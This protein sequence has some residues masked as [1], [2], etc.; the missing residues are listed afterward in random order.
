MNGK[1]DVWAFV[2]EFRNQYPDMLEQLPVDVLSVIELELR[3][4]VIPFP[5]LFRKYSVDAAIVPDFSGIYVDA[6]SYA[7]LE[8]KPIRQFNRLRFS[9]AHELGHIVMH[10]DLAPKQGFKSLEDFRA[11]TQTYNAQRFTLEQ[12]ANEFGGRLVVPVDRLNADF[13]L[14]SSR[15]KGA[16]PDFWVDRAM[17]EGFCERAGESYGVSREVISVRLDREEIWRQP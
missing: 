6:K 1:E 2:E 3:L 16:F 7:Y 9:L 11:W 17:R 12:Q 8:G 4:D 14:F 10:K 13:D 5:D 15:A